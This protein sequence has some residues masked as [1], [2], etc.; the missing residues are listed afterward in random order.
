MI[1][2]G[3]ETN[4]SC[5]LCGDV[6]LLVRTEESLLVSSFPPLTNNEHRKLEQ[7]HI[8]PTLQHQNKLFPE[9]IRTM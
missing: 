3:T 5:L 1:P 4:P 9:N 6:E 8:I 7:Q 2:T